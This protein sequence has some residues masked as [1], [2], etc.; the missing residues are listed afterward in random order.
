MSKLQSLKK[1]KSFSDVVP[2]IDKVQEVAQHGQDWSHEM[3]E[4]L[5][6]WMNIYYCD[7]S[8]LKVLLNHF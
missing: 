3:S 2:L 4:L 5:K 6:S 1:N 7:V 8:Y